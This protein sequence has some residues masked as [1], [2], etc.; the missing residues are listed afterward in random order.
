MKSH[1]AIS[2]RRAL[3]QDDTHYWVMR[4]L[5]ETPDISQRQLA[6]ELGISLGSVNFCLQALVDKGWIKMQNFTKSSHKMGYAYLLTPSGITE[7]AGLTRRFLKRKMEEY[8]LLKSEIESLQSEIPE[9]RR[10][11]L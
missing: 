10:T 6:K 5:Q 4:R 3:V 7:K 9:E 2:V 1:Q 8:E 11:G